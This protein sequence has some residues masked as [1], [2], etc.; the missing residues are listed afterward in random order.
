[1]A[2]TERKPLGPY[3]KDPDAERTISL[4]WEPEFGDTALH[5]GADPLIDATWI[6][7]GGITQMSAS[8]VG[9]KH[10]LKLSGGTAG[11]KY[12]VTSR[13]T[14]TSGEVD[15]QSILISVIQK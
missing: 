11:Q 5:P 7:P 12:R 14:T 3:E 2:T 10:F 13:V 9:Y 4:N 8:R 15:K 1:M 6:V